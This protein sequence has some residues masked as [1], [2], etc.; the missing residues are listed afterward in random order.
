MSRWK[1]PIA[2]IDAETDPFSKKRAL[3]DIIPEPFV[4]GF[5]D[6]GFMDESKP[7]YYFETSAELA[8]FIAD[9]EFII[10]A[11]NGGKFDFHYLKDFCDPFNPITAI[12]GRIARMQIGIAELRDSWNIL[13]VPLAL[14]QKQDQ[15]YSIHEY[16]ERRKPENWA[17]IL[18][19]LESDCRYLYQIVM[20]Y[21][22]RFGYHLTQAAGSMKEMNKKNPARLPQTQY[23][24]FYDRY[25]P[26]FFG[27]RVECFRAGIIDQPFKVVDINS[28]Y[29]FAMLSKHPYSYDVD[30]EPGDARP[31][32]T[33]EEVTA[34]FYTVRCVSHGAFPWRDPTG[35][36]D[37]GALAFPNDDKPREYNVTGWELQ[38][39]EETGTVS[40][41][42]IL[43]CHI[44]NELSEFKS[45][46]LDL[47][48]ER[49]RAK[50][51][52]DKAGDLLAKLAMNACY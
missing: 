5:Y 39:A 12:S 52:G 33:P 14:Y 27:G 31:E 30:I 22:Q 46:I 24:D 15:D 10:Y 6:G 16:T 17:R 18:D 19:Y 26:F 48:E 2:T 13:P 11:H 4:W 34:S 36:F 47:Y 38:A 49:R 23:P 3:N 51:E 32:M 28:A 21:R 25:H 20:A 43:Q 45:F 29:P 37:D 1:R 40:D 35:R 41:L 50:K 44:F 8:S 7:F 9:K 42:E